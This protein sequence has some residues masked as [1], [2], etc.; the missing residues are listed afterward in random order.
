MDSTDEYPVEQWQTSE[1][2]SCIQRATGEELK[3]LNLGV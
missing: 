3:Y 2:K 1:G